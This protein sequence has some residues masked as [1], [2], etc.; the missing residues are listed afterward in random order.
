MGVE[1][2]GPG[3]CILHGF[4]LGEDVLQPLLVEPLVPCRVRQDAEWQIE[5]ERS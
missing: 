2:H 4:E 3:V 1:A 5:E